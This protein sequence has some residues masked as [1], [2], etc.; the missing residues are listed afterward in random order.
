VWVETTAMK[1]HL[2]WIP[3]ALAALCLSACVPPTSS[4]GSPAVPQGTV[5]P[6]PAASATTG[7]RVVG[8]TIL[9]STGVP[10]VPIGANVGTVGNYDW[11]GIADGHSDSA[12]EWGWNTVRLNVAFAPLYAP[13]AS[14][15][16]HVQSVIDEYTAKGIVV[17]VASHD[18]L[19]SGTQAIVRSSL[20]TLAAQNRANSRVWFN[21]NNEPDVSGTAWVDLQ[22]SYVALIR[23]QGN[24]NIV[25]ADAVKDANDGSWDPSP[26]LDDPSGPPRVLAGNS[27]VVFATHNYGGHES[28]AGMTQYVNAVRANGAAVIVGEYGYLPRP[29]EDA[30]HKSSALANM[31]VYQSMGV[32]ILVWHATHGD[33]F[34]LKASGDPFY[35]AGCAGCALS[36]LGTHLWALTH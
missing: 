4:S 1:R 9:D 8:T 16:A 27:N 25:V 35:G 29:N 32:G 14:T 2:L 13:T 21:G 12:L 3:V 19:D 5:T 24:P 10:F 7:F 11:K 18:T 28:V 26:H 17:I 33:G 15:L 23:S 22:R 20:A 34:T 36:D 30:R 31:A 6:A